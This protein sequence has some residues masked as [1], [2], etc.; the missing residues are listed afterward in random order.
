MSRGSIYG[1]EIQPH[2]HRTVR[3]E[4]TELVG[5]EGKEKSD[6]NTDYGREKRRRG[7]SELLMLHGGQTTT[8]L[9]Q[10]NMLD[11]DDCSKLQDAR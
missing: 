8:A 9:D 7:E 11:Y 4:R 1:V 3:S 2:R 10:G 6:I 5:Q